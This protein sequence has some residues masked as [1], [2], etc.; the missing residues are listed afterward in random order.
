MELRDI[1]YVIC[2]NMA[3]KNI[4]TLDV[5]QTIEGNS[6]FGVC[7][8]IGIAKMFGFENEE[9]E[10]FISIDSDERI[11]MENKFLRYLKDYFDNEPNA[12]T[13]SKRFYTKVNLILNGIKL[14]HNKMVSLADIIKDNIR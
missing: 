2:S 13:T 14:N 5:N 7:I 11:F 8:F 3:V 1:R 4:H 12:N 10:E 9:V 6:Y